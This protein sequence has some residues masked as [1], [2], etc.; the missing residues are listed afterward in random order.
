MRDSFRFLTGESDGTSYMH[1]AQRLC[2]EALKSLIDNN[3]DTIVTTLTPF[4]YEHDG[5]IYNIQHIT[6]SINSITN[7]IMYTAMINYRRYGFLLTY[8]I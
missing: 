7:R 8:E 5:R 3:F 2:I 1:I 4:D 6:Y